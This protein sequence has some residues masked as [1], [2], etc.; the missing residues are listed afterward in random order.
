MSVEQLMD[1][2]LVRRAQK[3][4]SGPDEASQ[5]EIQSLIDKGGAELAER[6]A[7]P[8]RFGTAGLRGLLGAGRAE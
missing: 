2:A 5:H 4:V 8:L 6:F 7:G 1:E 3:W